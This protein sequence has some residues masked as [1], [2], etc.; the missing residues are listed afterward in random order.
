MH[1]LLLK[2]PCFLDRALKF[3]LR[4]DTRKILKSENITVLMVSHD[5]NDALVVADKLA[6]MS[7]G[8]IAQIGPPKE[9]VL[10]PINKEIKKQFVCETG[11]MLYWK[12]ILEEESQ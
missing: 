1:K 6:I 11:D 5:Y 4:M 7:D 3:S 2:L 10:N 12:S 9:V 8:K